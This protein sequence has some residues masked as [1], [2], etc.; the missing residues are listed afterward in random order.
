MKSDH[1]ERG[2]LSNLELTGN[3]LLL[4]Q[5]LNLNWFL[6]EYCGVSNSMIYMSTVSKKNFKFQMATDVFRFY[7]QGSKLSQSRPVAWCC[8]LD[9]R[10]LIA[11]DTSVLGLL[12]N[13]LV[14]YARRYTVCVYEALIIFCLLQ[15]HLKFPL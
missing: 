2:L 1:T 12:A 5:T 4:D 8:G 6:L 3:R 14:F 10:Y 11:Q 15:S 13:I 7:C 9:L